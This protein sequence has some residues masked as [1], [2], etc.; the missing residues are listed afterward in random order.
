MSFRMKQARD[1]ATPVCLAVDD[2][3]PR[4][5]KDLAGLLERLHAVFVGA[6]DSAPSE[7][8]GASAAATKLS[9]S[10]AFKAEATKLVLE[11]G[12]VAAELD[13][14]SQLVTDATGDSVV[15]SVRTMSAAALAL[16]KLGARQ[17]HPFAPQSAYVALGPAAVCGALTMHGC[18]R[19]L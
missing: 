6:S 12:G 4:V 7:Q 8:S 15:S 9:T 19:L 14:L 3:I 1:G 10:G 18:A 2:A 17:V 13:A 5:Q 16:C 11:T